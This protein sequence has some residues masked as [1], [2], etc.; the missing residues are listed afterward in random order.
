M[1]ISTRGSP[2][3]EKTFGGG[4]WMQIASHC[5]LASPRHAMRHLPLTHSALHDCLKR[6]GVNRLPE[7][8]GDKPQQ[9]KF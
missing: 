9:K 7:M 5:C 8:A 1:L 2:L 3:R 6:H 4:R